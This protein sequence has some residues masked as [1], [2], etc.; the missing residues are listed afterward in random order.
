MI[1]PVY[2]FS[3]LLSINICVWQNVLYFLDAPRKF[4]QNL[5]RWLIVIRRSR[6]AKQYAVLTFNFLNAC[7]SHQ[8]SSLRRIKNL[9]FEIVTTATK[10]N[11][12][13]VYQPS[14]RNIL[15]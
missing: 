15:P 14:R 2:S 4:R 5:S 12:A 8:D 7:L 10:C 11:L 13:G 9:R 3:F 1:K 6:L